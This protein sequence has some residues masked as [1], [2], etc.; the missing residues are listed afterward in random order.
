MNTDQ[1]NALVLEQDGQQMVP[2]LHKLSL[3]ELPDG[4]VLV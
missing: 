1:F 4:D 3:A 2:H